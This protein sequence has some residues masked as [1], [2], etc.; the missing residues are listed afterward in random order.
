MSVVANPPARGPA[1][2]DLAELAAEVARAAGALLLA[3]AGSALAVT[4]KS[5]GT[6]P[7]TEAD[8][9][10]E[11][12]LVDALLRA[13]PDDGLLGEEGADRAGTTGLRWVVDPLDG[14]VNYLYGLPGWTVSV[15]CE[16]RE[17][18]GWRGIAGAVHHPPADETFR[19]WRGGGAWS[20]ERRLGVNDPVALDRA[21]VATG[22][23]YLPEVRARQAA[24][25]AALLPRVRDLRRIG[26][27]ALD[28]CLVAAG[29]VDAYYEDSCSRWDWA[30][31]AVVASEAG[32]V[33]TPLASPEGAVGALAAGPA[34]HAALRPHVEP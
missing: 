31:G 30:A 10:A 21:L 18:D 20:G 3:R 26:S 11:A 17:G 8:R 29:R 23:G 12:L 24:V 22:F 27:A 32:A 5:S 13:R 28:L 7:V 6:D 25:A 4:T 15:A 34:L 1:A 33:V 14:T 16:Q 2:S 9:A 19:A